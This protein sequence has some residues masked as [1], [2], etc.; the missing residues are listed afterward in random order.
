MFK[1]VA[2]DLDDTLWHN[3]AYYRQAKLDFAQLL[4]RYQRGETIQRRLDEIEVENIA[5]YGY[6][7]KSFMLSMVEAALELSD[8]R[9]S[10]ADMAQVLEIGKAMLARE[11]DLFEGTLAVLKELCDKCDLMMITKGDLFE[12]Q[13]KIERSGIVEYFKYVEVLSEKTP[14]AYQRILEKHAV[15]PGNFLMVG[16]SLR[17]DVLPVVSIGGHAVYIP[18]EHPWFHELPADDERSSA[19]YTELDHLGLLPAYI[20]SRRSE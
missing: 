1:I 4:S 8:E 20:A 16:N 3:E 6:G 9:I 14:T 19:E 10:G 5:H 11:V 15:G 2:F 7:I 13:R 17:S 12:Q 18:D